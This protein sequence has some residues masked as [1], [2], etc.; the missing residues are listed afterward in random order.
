[1]THLF[2]T[3]ASVNA[4]NS[5]LYYLSVGDKAQVKVI[6]IVVGDI[7][8]DLKTQMKN[9]IPDDPTKTMGLFSVL[10]VATKTKYD[11]TTNIDVADGLTNGAECVIEIIDYRVENSSRP[12]I[13]W[14]SFPLFDIGKK[15]HR[16]HAHLYKTNINKNWTPI[17]EVTRQFRINK[18]NQI[19]IIRRQF[20]L[21]PPAAKT[22]HRCQGDT[23]DEAIV[24]FLQS[25]GEHMHYVGLSRV[26]NSSRL[27]IVDLNENRIRVSEKVQ[28]Q[29]FRLR[30][31][32]SLMPLAALRGTDS[33][34]TATV[35]FHNVRSL[36]LHIDDVR[37]DFYIKKA[38]ID[39]LVETKLCRTDTDCLYNLT[40]CTLHR[41]D[42]SQCVPEHAMELLYTLKGL[43]HAV[44]GN[45]V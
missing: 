24:D 7:S 36:H 8:D 9:K 20:P 13:I 42:C 19:K 4:H 43:G 2:T 41:N 40:G 10:P 34:D 15:Q 11:L 33:S 14:V 45:F 27:H 21:R 5:A 29:M 30:T 28:K 44:L 18:K 32:A 12:S 23:L 1:M 22:I 25:T 35:L 6:D 3:N 37:S 31:E 39:I 26:R 17:L 38:D 16:E